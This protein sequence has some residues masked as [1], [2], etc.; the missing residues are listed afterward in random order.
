MVFLA[1]WCGGLKPGLLA[2]ALGLLVGLMVLISDQANRRSYVVRDRVALVM[3]LLEGLA[4]SDSFE[5]MHKAR[6]R[7]ERKQRQLEAEVRERQRIEQEL[8]EADRRKDEFLATLAHEL[9]NPLAPIRNC[10]AITQP[11]Q[12]RP[13]S[14]GTNPPHDGTAGPANG[15]AR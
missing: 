3:F 9:R 4:I 7:L 13:R 8:V 5:A 12:G 15:A 1:A 2:T 14:P 11:D 10:L 6:R